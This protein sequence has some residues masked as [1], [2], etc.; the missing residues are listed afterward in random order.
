MLF[1]YPAIFHKEEQSALNALLLRDKRYD[2]LFR[3]TNDSDFQQQLMIHYG[4]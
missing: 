1:V 4:L 2:D 3:S